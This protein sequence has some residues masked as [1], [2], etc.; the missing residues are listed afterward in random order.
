MRVAIREAEGQLQRSL[1]GDRLERQQQMSSV[2]AVDHC[3]DGAASMTNDV[4][5]VAGYTGRGELGPEY[6]LYRR[7]LEQVR[8]LA[9]SMETLQASCRRALFD[10][11]SYIGAKL[12]ACT[13]TALPAPGLRRTETT[14]LM[15]APEKN[16]TCYGSPYAQA[17]HTAA[18]E[19]QRY[20]K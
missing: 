19:V 5:R 3:A 7:T 11:A 18:D 12:S 16:A 15:N 2:Q 6:S 9:Q 4:L 17:V 13:E 14:Q 20:I 1:R 10:A 8:L